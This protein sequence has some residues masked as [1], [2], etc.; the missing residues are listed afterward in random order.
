MRPVSCNGTVVHSPVATILTRTSPGFGAATS[1]SSIDSGRP[2]AQAT[3]ALDFTVGT[4]RSGLEVA[5]RQGLATSIPRAS[6]PGTRNILSPAVTCRGLTCS[7]GQRPSQACAAPA[8][9]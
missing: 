5:V 4:P 1:T 2:A 3:A 8:T 6:A 7:G 9:G